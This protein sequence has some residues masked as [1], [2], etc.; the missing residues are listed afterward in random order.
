MTAGRRS[1]PR[2]QV[3]TRP[4]TLDIRLTTGII[5]NYDDDNDAASDDDDDKEVVKEG[6][7]VKIM[8]MMKES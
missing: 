3:K 8:M 2:I 4:W 7:K 6:K 5:A 1:E